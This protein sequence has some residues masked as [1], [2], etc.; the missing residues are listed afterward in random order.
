[1]DLHRVPGSGQIVVDMDPVERHVERPGR[2][3]G[4]DDLPREAQT[5]PELAEAVAGATDASQNVRAR[6]ALGHRIGGLGKEP[7]EVRVVPAEI[8]ASGVAVLPDPF[9]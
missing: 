5:P 9:P 8:V 4:R 1:M 3:V 7:P 6:W 2:R